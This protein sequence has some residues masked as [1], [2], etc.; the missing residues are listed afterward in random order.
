[1]HRGRRGG[2]EVGKRADA[3]NLPFFSSLLR[4][5]SFTSVC[6]IFL[7]G[8]R[9]FFIICKSQGLWSWMEEGEENDG[10]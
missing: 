7:C 2:G 3:E 6:R 5:I 8:A 1:M 9:R 10:K 4:S